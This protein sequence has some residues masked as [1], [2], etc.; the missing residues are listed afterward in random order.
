MK[1]IYS[2]LLVGCLMIA[3]TS[4][5]LLAQVPNNGFENWTAG[6][7]YDIPTDWETPN[8][9]ISGIPGNTTFVAFEES[10]SV[11]AGSKALKLMSQ[12]LTII[13]TT[14]QVPGFATLGDVNLNMSTYSFDISG[15]VPVTGAPQKL[16]G[17]YNYTPVNNDHC[18]F[19]LLLYNYDVVNNVIIDTVGVGYFT[20]NQATAG[21][22]Y[23]EANVTYT[24]SIVPNYMNIN[25]LSSDHNNIQAGSKLYVDELNLDFGTT[26]GTNILSFTLPQQ[27]GPATI[28]PVAHTVDISVASG[29]ALTALV[30]TISVATGSTVSP[31][32]GVAQDFTN[33]VTYTVADGSGATQAW[34]V[35][36][37]V[38]AEPELFISEYIEG[39]SNNKGMEIYN[40]KSSAVD[41]DDYVIL[42][43]SNANGWQ[44]VHAFPA[45]AV[46][47]AQDV[48]VM[49]TDQVDVALFAASGADEVLGFPSLC[50]FNGN[51]ARAIAKIVGSDT[52]IV[53]QFGDPDVDPGNGWSV[54]GVAEATKEHT[55]Q[56]KSTV[57]TGNTD[58]AASFG[59]DATNSEWIVLAQND[60]SGLG[61]HGAGGNIPPVISQ[62]VLLP[63]PVTPTDTVVI[64]A[65]VADPDGGTVTQVTLAWGLDGVS[66]PNNL[67][68]SVVFSVYSSLPNA[69]PAQ[70]AGTDI[71]YRFEAIDNDNDTSVLI[72]YYTVESPAVNV[73]IYDIQGQT[74]TSPYEGQ[75]VI[76][77]GIVTALL[78]GTYPGY[79]IQD[80]DG[81]W[82]GLYVF[83]SNTPAIGDEITI[84]GEI[85]EYYDLTEIKNLS[86][87]TVNS[88]GNTLPNPALLTTNEIND[89]AYESVFV[90][91]ENA[92]CT[93]DDAG[94][95]MWEVN[96]G[97]GATLVHN[98]DSYTFTPT[99][100]THY[101]VQGALNYSYS[102][103]KIEIRMADDVTLYN[104]IEQV[105]DSELTLYPNPVSSTLSISAEKQ[106]VKVAVYD[107]LGNEIMGVVPSS[108]RIELDV[109]GFV[110]GVYFIKL[111]G[112]DG[113]IATKRFV[114]K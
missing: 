76:T 103:W 29:T 51:D 91:V 9:S 92:E 50:H 54:A 47:N 67:P 3:F 85:V 95:G 39:S 78:P 14:I 64:S 41:L 24:A 102:E 10:D 63:D 8:A 35:S 72:Q 83:D 60:F 28:D 61:M 22:Q 40:P 74:A 68:L 77:T 36:V 19:E 18:L 107:I 20:S 52:I 59:T 75:S 105:E 58:W 42:Q 65:N 26:S 30:P 45:G 27:T 84:E 88:S 32:S 33:S 16:T 7:T 94:Y 5:Q 70:P 44:Y 2:L 17:Y 25:I 108:T 112:V 90:R 57:T 49:I 11:Y 109:R 37:S 80:G 21:W 79:F 56:R 104:G 106:Y 113:I 82:N 13:T 15:G 4:T 38:A 97:T 93:N 111:E 1:K 66:F 6:M 100:G 43:A 110:P 12:D 46:L 73:S 98:N 96:D 62:V 87:Y 31:A 81:A 101:N 23:F 99:L 69:I 89:E 48:W 71:Y 55:L 34:V 86:S 53:D 114:K